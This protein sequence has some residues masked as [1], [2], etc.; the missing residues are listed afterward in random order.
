MT[1]D[2]DLL[3]KMNFLD[4]HVSELKQLNWRDIIKKQTCIREGTHNKRNSCHPQQLRK[5]WSVDYS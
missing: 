3:V 2:P 5:L 1:A 4:G